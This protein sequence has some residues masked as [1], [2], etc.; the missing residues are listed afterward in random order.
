M[1]HYAN[2]NYQNKIMFQFHIKTQ[3]SNGWYTRYGL[4]VLNL[5]HT[6]YISQ[7]VKHR[8]KGHKRMS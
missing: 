7:T 6:R 3:I 5:G 4:V 1:L 8:L 2:A